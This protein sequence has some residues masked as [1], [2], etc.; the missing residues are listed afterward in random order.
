VEGSRQPQSNVSFSSSPEYVSKPPPAVG[1]SPMA[2]T[3]DPPPSPVKHLLH[4]LR[5]V[6]MDFR[7]LATA[8]GLQPDGYRTA[9]SPEQKPLV[10]PHSS[11][12]GVRSDPA[13]RPIRTDG[14]FRFCTNV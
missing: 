14:P 1:T 10:K 8:V 12:T 7:F 6:A 4:V 3:Q 5:K 11:I 9:D 2:P 13:K